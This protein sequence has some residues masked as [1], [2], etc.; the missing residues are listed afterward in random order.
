MFLITD[1]LPCS[2]IVNPSTMLDEESECPC[3]ELWSISNQF[4]KKNLTLV[5]IGVG[6]FVSLCDNLYGSISQNTGNAHTRSLFQSSIRFLCLGGEYIPLTNA[7]RVLF[8]SIQSVIHQGYTLSQSLR[9]IKRDEFEK[10]SSYYC[11]SSVPNTKHSQMMA[12]KG[13]WLMHHADQ[14]EEDS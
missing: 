8:W 10:N 12:L 2:Y 14:M 5:I 9:H 13:A 7:G 1:G 6:P 4:I 3:D 11:C